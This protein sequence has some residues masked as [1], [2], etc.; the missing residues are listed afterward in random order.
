MFN[1]LK[2]YSTRLLKKLFTKSK[3]KIN[4]NKR[5]TKIVHNPFITVIRPKS[6]KEV[7]GK[8]KNT[9]EIKKSQT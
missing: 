6:I 4:N 3:L 9:E 5:D 2:T 8:N 1:F 7:K